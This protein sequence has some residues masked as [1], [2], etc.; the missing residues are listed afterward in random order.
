V[1]RP[2]NDVG[3]HREALRASRNEQCPMANAQ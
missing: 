3:N 2:V 1:Q